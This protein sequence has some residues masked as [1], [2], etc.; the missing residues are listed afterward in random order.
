MSV[1]HFKEFLVDQT[2]CPMKINT[3]GVLLGAIVNLDNA[4][5]IL[6][7]G[8]GTGV[9]ALMM[10]QRNNNT[11]IDAIDI[12]FNAFEKAKENF[13]HSLFHAQLTAHHHGFKEYF[14]LK[15]IVKYDLIVSNPPFFLNALHSP[16]QTKNIAR[17]TDENFFIDLIHYASNHLNPQGIL[18]L[19]LPID[20]SLM[21]QNIA[22]SYN[23]KL[24]RCIE[25][26]S[27]ESK[28]PFRHIISF[29]NSNKLVQIT[30]ETFCIYETQGVHSLQYKKLLKNFFTIF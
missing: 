5:K 27:F 10:A 13:D 14:E 25:V 28:A 15:P 30:K 8:T 23:F 18:E 21:L 19:V 4:T 20:I 29:T 22:A 6:D 16:N 12:D 17:H 11:L 7:I 9:I 26:K 24:L 2:N 3:D 1:F